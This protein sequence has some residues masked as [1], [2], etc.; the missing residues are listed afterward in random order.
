MLAKHWC[1][2]LSQRY[3]LA[4]CPCEKRRFWQNIK[5]SR[6]FSLYRLTPDRI[7]G[8]QLLRGCSTA[9]VWRWRDGHRAQRPLCGGGGMDTE[10][11]G[12]CVEVRDGH[13]AQRPLCGGG[14]MDTQLNGHCVEVEGWT[15]SSTATVWRWRDGHTAQRLLCGDP[16]GGELTQWVT[17]VLMPELVRERTSSDCGFVR[18]YEEES[19]LAV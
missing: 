11:N 3:L 5:V 7:C 13:T 10:L 9:T 12:H 16:N 1:V 15:H 4:E 8:G 14:G 2:S 17:A 19:L 6:R 18:W